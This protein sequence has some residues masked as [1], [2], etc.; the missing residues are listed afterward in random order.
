MPIYIFKREN[1]LKGVVPNKP[2]V[3]KMY[4]RKKDVIYIGHASRLR[5]RVQSYWQKDDLI[6]EHNEKKRLRPHIEY[7]SYSVMPRK[8][9]MA[10]ER[11]LKKKCK[12]NIL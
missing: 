11:K 7:Y 9:A 4:N 6:H 5:H 10:L 12:Y 3:Y 8:K 2:G 1:L